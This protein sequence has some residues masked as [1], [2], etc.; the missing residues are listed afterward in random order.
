MVSSKRK[1]AMKCARLISYMALASFALPQAVSAQIF[2]KAPNYSGL[3]VTALEP[4]FDQPMPG[5]TPKEINAALAWNL[6]SALNIAALQCQFEPT[7]RTV[8]NYN[9]LIGDHKAELDAAYASLNAY[10]IR[11]KK[12]VKAGQ[13]ALDTF[14]TRTIS[15]YSTVTGQL[16]FCETAGRVGKEALFTPK[17]G[18]FALATKRLRELRN[19]LKPA[20]EQHFGSVMYLRMTR[21]ALPDLDPKCWDKKGKYIASCGTI[22]GG[23]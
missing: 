9:A 7:L 19:S 11:S 6:R 5:A 17:G 4:G 2:Y 22:Y 20:G 3:P 13:A 18:F 8:E 21:T 1:P 12:A 15:A 23:G 16:G 14:G 10:Y